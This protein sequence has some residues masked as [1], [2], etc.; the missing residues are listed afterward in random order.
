MVQ[1]NKNSLIIIGIFVVLFVAGLYLW[2]RG[3]TVE[4]SPD[5]S[6][7]PT[8]VAQ[9]KAPYAQGQILVKFKSDVSQEVIANRL[10]E[11]HASVQSTIIGI[12]T[13]I[14]AVPP[15]K[16]EEAIHKLFR[17][18]DEQRS[19]LSTSFVTLAPYKIEIISLK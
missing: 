19:T 12:G 8:P 7:T 15:G 13:S 6:L 17:L 14:V 11:L 2:I 16:E 4:P 10:N 9:K 18:I 3:T 1:R 5:G